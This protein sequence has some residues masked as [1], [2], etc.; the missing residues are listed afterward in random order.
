MGKDH[1]KTKISGDGCRIFLPGVKD[2][3]TPLPAY[4]QCLSGRVKEELKKRFM[5]R[6]LRITAL[7]RSALLLWHGSRIEQAGNDGFQAVE[8][9]FR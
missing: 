4:L 3:D 1:K 9:F 8:G 6:Y 2:P 5:I 7:I